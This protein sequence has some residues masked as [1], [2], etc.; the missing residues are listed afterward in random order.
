MSQKTKGI[1]TIIGSAFC[2]ALMSMFVRLAGDL[3]SLQK[4]FFRNFVA[5]IFASIVLL[6]SEEKFHFNKSNLGYL[7]LRAGFGTMGLLC[8][9]YAVDHLLLSDASLLNK[10]SPFFAIIGSAVI[11]KE[12]IKP[13][14]AL[15]VITAFL[16]CVLVIKPG[17]GSFSDTVASLA[18]LMGGFGAGIAYTMVRVLTQRG[19]RGPFIV[20]F[21]SLFSSLVTLPYMLFNYHPMTAF[22][23]ISLMMAGLSAAGGQFFITAA[24]SFA[25]AKEISVFDYTNILFAAMLGFLVFGQVPDILSILGYII[26]I[27]VS[28]GM[29][30]YNTRI[31]ENNNHVK[32]KT[33]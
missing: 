25:P 28:V 26:I 21:F 10:L 4:S 11:L 16:G 8:N 17:A 13:V 29:F 14:Q 15:A 19:E 31:C 22:Q 2:F 20:F 18:G 6:R 33:T 12:R 9:F 23:F 30:I 24:Y 7:L 32:E 3:P 5:V 27:A 1:F